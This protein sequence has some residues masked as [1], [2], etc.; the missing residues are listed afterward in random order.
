[1]ALTPDDTQHVSIAGV[2]VGEIRNINIPNTVRADEEWEGDFEIWNV[3]DSVGIFMPEATGDCLTQIPDWGPVDILPGQGETVRHFK[4]V[5]PGE[6]TIKLKLAT[7][8]QGESYDVNVGEGEAARLVSPQKRLAGESFDVIVA[9]S[10][11]PLEAR[12]R[13]PTFPSAVGP[14]EEWYG[15]IETW[16]IGARMGYFVLESI[17]DIEIWNKKWFT[18][19]PAGHFYLYSAYWTGPIRLTLKFNTVEW[20]DAD[21]AVVTVGPHTTVGAGGEL[22]NLVISKEFVQDGESWMGGIQVWNIGDASGNFRLVFTGDITGTSLTFTLGPI[23]HAAVY[24]EDIGPKVFTITAQ[25]EVDGAW[26]DDDSR[27][28]EAYKMANCMTA[29]YY[30]GIKHDGENSWA[31]GVRMEVGNHVFIYSP[32]GSQFIFYELAEGKPYWF[33]IRHLGQLDRYRYVSWVTPPGEDW[34]RYNYGINILTYSHPHP[35]YP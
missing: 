14:D 21:T 33:Q 20:A 4:G 1:M 26:V 31:L 34:V 10:T 32:V 17:C 19:L 11:A 3:G 12:M 29:I 27:N 30:V 9:P 16:N 5:G 22:R 6:V 23:E 28:V 2:A 35:G 18:Q 7:L 24:F 15:T 8:G 13:N 25:R